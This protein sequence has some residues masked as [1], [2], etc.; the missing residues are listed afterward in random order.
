MKFIGDGVD[1]LVEC[2]FYARDVVFTS[3]E[4]L[5]AIAH[6]ESIH[7]VRL[8]VFTK[9]YAGV[10]DVISELKT[11]ADYVDI[12]VGPRKGRSPKP[13]PLPLIETLGHLGVTAANAVMRRRQHVD[14]KCARAAD[15]QA[16]GVSF[17]YSSIFMRK[18]APDATTE[19]YAEFMPAYHSLTARAP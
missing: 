9:I 10:P 5:A 13:S 19:S 6:Y 14:V 16:I 12:V 8:T 4:L 7:S 15:V 17:S 1:A 18:L 3:D 11:K 2:A